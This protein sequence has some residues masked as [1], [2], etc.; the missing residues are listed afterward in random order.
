M[1]ESLNVTKP[2]PRD[3]L[4]SLFRMMRTRS[5][6]PTLLNSS[7]K[8]ASPTS[9]DKLETRTVRSSSS[10]APLP[11]PLPPL[12][13]GGMYTLGFPSSSPPGFAFSL[14]SARLAQIV[15]FLDLPRA[16]STCS[17]KNR[18]SSSTVPEVC[19]RLRYLSDNSN[20]VGSAS[21]RAVFS[22]GSIS[23]PNF[24]HPFRSRTLGCSFS[25]FLV[26]RTLRITLTVLPSRSTYSVMVRIP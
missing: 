25:T 9:S 12:A 23:L 17:S 18:L 15:C 26:V 22:S 10:R 3:S 13:L 2:N 5:T 24:F 20:I 8:S 21:A 19:S 7:C 14:A 4:V 11:S 6:R 1:R 16:R